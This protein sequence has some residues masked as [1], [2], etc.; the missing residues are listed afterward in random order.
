MLGLW[1]SQVGGMASILHF[2]YNQNEDHKMFLT[3]TWGTIAIPKIIFLK[4]MQMAFES[5]FPLLFRNVLCKFSVN[6]Q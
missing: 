2:N 1:M 3:I 4:K 5:P 6:M